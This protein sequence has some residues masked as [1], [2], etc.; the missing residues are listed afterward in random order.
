MKYA[1]V[2]FDEGEQASPFMAAYTQMTEKL[3]D[4][5]QWESKYQTASDTIAS[6]ETELKDL[7]QFKADTEKEALQSAL[8]AVFARFEDLVGVEAFDAL[9]ENA[10]DFTPE[11]LEEKCFAIRGR[12][13]TPA[14]F[15][16][17]E[18]APKLQVVRED[19]RK[20]EP[21]GGIFA[22]FGIEAE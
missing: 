13:G 12:S 21:Y 1:I 16:H 18:K 8:E 20:K 11:E 15:S 14:K 6:M 10:E 3:G 22:H 7:R 5:V 2:E 4:A 9:R 17:E 19:N